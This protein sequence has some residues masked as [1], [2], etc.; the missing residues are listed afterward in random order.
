MLLL[1]T[2]SITHMHNCVMG[3]TPSN[4]YCAKV[5]DHK[6]LNALASSKGPDKPSTYAQPHQSLCDSHT[7]SMDVDEDDSNQYL[8]LLPRWIHQHEHFKKTFAHMH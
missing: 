7:L 8:D 1:V 2:I 5:C 4:F 6:I 3:A